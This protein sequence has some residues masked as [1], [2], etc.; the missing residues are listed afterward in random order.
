MTVA[1]L[2][3][4]AVAE[5]LLALKIAFLVLLYLLIWRILR[6]AAQRAADPPR[7]A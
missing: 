4:T 5:V 7:T 2:A 3:S 6:T 1:V